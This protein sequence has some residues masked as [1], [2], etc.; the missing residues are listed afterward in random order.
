MDIKIVKRGD[1]PIRIRMKIPYDKIIEGL[2]SNHDVVVTGI[3]PQTAYYASKKL[4]RMLGEEVIALPSFYLNER[5]YVFT[6]K[7]AI[8]EWA[9]SQ[10]INVSE[11]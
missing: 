6:T 2:K 10:G 9:R 4:T 3:K 7:S 11:D 5:G 8:I 1:V